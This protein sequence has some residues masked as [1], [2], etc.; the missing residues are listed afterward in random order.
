VQVANQLAGKE[1][2]SPRPE[3]NL[4]P[5]LEAVQRQMERERSEHRRRLDLLETQL[6]TSSIDNQVSLT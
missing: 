5:Q 6:E 2:S 3:A 1:R 4:K